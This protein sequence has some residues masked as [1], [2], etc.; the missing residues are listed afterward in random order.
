MSTPPEKTQDGNVS[1]DRSATKQSKIAGYDLE[2]YKEEPSIAAANRFDDASNPA[3]IQLYSNKLPAPSYSI[4]AEKKD[5]HEE[6][7][8]ASDTHENY[9]T[10]SSGDANDENSDNKPK[11]NGLPE[12]LIDG[13]KNLSGISLDDVKVHY[14]SSKPA[15]LDAHAF[16]QGNNIFLASG[17]E[18]HLAHEAWHIVQQKQGRVKTTDT[19]SQ[20]DRI[21]ADKLLEKE[22]DDMGEKVLNFEKEEHTSSSLFSEH[23]S[24]S[25]NEI[26]QGKFKSKGKSENDIEEWVERTRREL[27]ADEETLLLEVFNKL[28]D[29]KKK[30]SFDIDGTLT[31]TK[32]RLRDLI[33]ENRNGPIPT[34]VEEGSAVVGLRG[35]VTGEYLQ[36]KL[37]EWE[38]KKKDDIELDESLYTVLSHVTKEGDWMKN[39]IDTAHGSSKGELGQGFYTVEGHDNVGAEAIRDEFGTE[40]VQGST[41]RRTKQN[42]A[43]DVLTFYIENSEIRDLVVQNEADSDL[44]DFLLHILIHPNG[45]PD[46]CDAIA[47]IERINLMGKVLIFPDDKDQEVIID[48]SLLDE[49]TGAVKRYSYN[50]YRELNGGGTTHSVIISPQAPDS[51]SNIRQICFRGALGDKLINEAQRSKS[52]L[53]PAQIPETYK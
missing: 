11:N 31:Q 40:Q 15:E 16:A 1:H 38:P 34:L 17:Q 26:I 23:E 47:L 37:E 21:N 9:L 36:R 49:E 19:T 45:Y 27:Q 51:L 5:G 12:E 22:A 10:T 35:N 29:S 6:D 33:L 8:E 7:K 18:K 43:R 50:T 53:G 3:P 13:I 52:R 39:R 42:P 2:S 48:N 25:P 28:H 32:N 46:N 44:G 24:S 30:F 14:N 20:G 41:K 4:Q